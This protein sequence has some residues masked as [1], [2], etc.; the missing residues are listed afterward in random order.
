MLDVWQEAA[1]CSYR[2]DLRNELTGRPYDILGYLSGT[3]VDPGISKVTLF[4]WVSVSRPFEER[5]AF[6]TSENT[7]TATP[8]SMPEDRGLKRSPF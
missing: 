6:Q 5:T 1:T 2:K 3:N 7:H 4:C 8:S